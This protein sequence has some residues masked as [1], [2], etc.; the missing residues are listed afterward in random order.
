MSCM[1]EKDAN[2]LRLAP[3]TIRLVIGSTGTVV[4][5]PNEMGLPS[6]FEPKSH[7]WGFIFSSLFSSL[8]LG[9]ISVALFNYVCMLIV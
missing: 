1:Q 2:A 6:I 4:T 8:N 3:N 5:F 7:R 9:S